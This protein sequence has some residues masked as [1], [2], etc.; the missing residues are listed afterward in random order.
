MS[1]LDPGHTVQ[2]SSSMS[3]AVASVRSWIGETPSTCVIVA[4]V[5]AGKSHLLT[6]VGHEVADAV[7]MPPPDGSDCTDSIALLKSRSGLS[8]IADDLDKFSKGL[9][10]ELIRL[11]VASDHSLLASMTELSTRTR[12]LL[13]AKRPDTA[14]VFL[15]DLVSRPQDVE[16]FVESWIVLNCLT[17]DLVAIQE[18]AKFCCASGMPEGFRTVDGFLGGLK[19]AGWGFCQAPSFWSRSYESFIMTRGFPS[20]ALGATAKPS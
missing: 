10:E 4:A 3:A 8:V 5:G 6:A 19:G 18:C 15:D 9:R 7:V 12:N 14:L 11:V 16:A 17:G 13:L 2:I 20:P 1:L